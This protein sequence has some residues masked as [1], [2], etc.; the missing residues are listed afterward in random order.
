MCGSMGPRL[1]GRWGPGPIDGVG[2]R[3]CG[4]GPT[5]ASI[6]PLFRPRLHSVREL[7]KRVA[8]LVQPHFTYKRNA[9]ATAP[10]V[11]DGCR[12]AVFV[13][14]IAF[15]VADL[16]VTSPWTLKDSPERGMERELQ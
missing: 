12:F 11:A 8:H 4:L 15:H 5:L 7:C 10:D 2:V 3:G 16:R 14:E 13:E 6:G 1:A 9:S